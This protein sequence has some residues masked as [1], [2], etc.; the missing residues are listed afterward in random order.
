MDLFTKNLISDLKKID[1][2]LNLEEHKYKDDYRLDIYLNVF[3][4]DRGITGEYV[5]KWLCSFV[6]EGNNWRCSYVS[7]IFKKLNQQI[8]NMITSKHF[9]IKNYTEIL[10]KLILNEQLKKISINKCKGNNNE[11]ISYPS[12]YQTKSGK[13]LLDLLEED[14]LSDSEYIGFLKGNFYKYIYRYQRKNGKEDLEKAQFYLEELK[15]YEYK[16]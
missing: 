7:E 2:D 14:L 15:N 1:K 13:Q 16:D 11:N 8:I 5:R 10:N 12:R 3:D 6:L 4:E 9:S